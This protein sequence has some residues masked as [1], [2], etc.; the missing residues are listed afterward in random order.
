MMLKFVIPIALALTSA[1]TFAAP[2]VSLAS[3]IS[4]IRT[5]AVGGRTLVSYESPKQVSPGDRLSI[6]LNY[7]NESGKPADH[8]VVT[9]PV[10][11]GLAFTGEA[12]SGAE[13]SVDG[14]KTF[15]SLSSLQVV[16]AQGH[17]RAASAADVTHIRWKFVHPIAPG[18]RG[19]L[20]FEALVK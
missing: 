13:V 8:F 11:N 17:S 6:A 9:D 19:Q 14:G 2:Q 4:V 1:P 10:P 12:S 7:V 20:K 5:K 15:A 18:E 3:S 16:D